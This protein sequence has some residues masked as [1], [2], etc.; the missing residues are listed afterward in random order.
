MFIDVNSVILPDAYGQKRGL[1]S[2]KSHLDGSALDEYDLEQYDDDTVFY[3]VF[4][5]YKNQF[6]YTVGPPFLNLEKRLSPISCRMNNGSERRPLQISEYYDHK[7]AIGRMPLRGL[8]LDE[9]NAVELDFNGCFKWEG[10]VGLNRHQTA[11]VIL[12]T[13]Q[14]NNRVRWITEWMEFYRSNYGVG[15]TIIYDNGSDNIDELKALSG[16]G[17][18][19]VSWPY[20]YGPIRSHDNQFCQLGSLNHC[21]LKFGSNNMIMNFDIDEMLYAEK[22]AFKK[23]ISRYCLILFNGYRVPFIK[24]ASEDYSYADFSFRDKEPQGG[25][26]KYLYRPDR[27]LVNNVHSAFIKRHAAG[28]WRRLENRYYRLSGA[29]GQGL[30]HRILLKLISKIL[31]VKIVPITEAHFFHYTGITNN[32]KARYWDRMEES[33]LS[34]RHIRFNLHE[35]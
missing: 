15:R 27:V 20:K 12:T 14:K 6:L 11:P 30:F 31:R 13:I 21:R 26:R 3:D 10:R 28:L 32:W 17:L 24:P 7:V 23:Y 4:L 29:E 16:C 5:D 9:E 35:S 18:E 22:Q 2:D 33:V 1:R 25:G 8:A 19:I 34:D